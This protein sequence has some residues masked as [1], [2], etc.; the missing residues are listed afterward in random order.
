MRYR[1]YLTNQIDEM[2]RIDTLTGMYNRR[3]FALAYQ[4]LLET[5]QD[6][7]QLTIILADLDRL[8]Y[9]NDTF[10]H[11]EGD[12]AIRAVADA[13]VAVCPEGSLFN[14]FGGDEMLGVCRGRLEPEDIRTA[15]ADYF[16]KFNSNSD[17]PYEV[18]AS[19]GVY[20]TKEQDRLSFEELIERSDRLM[21]EEKERHRKKLQNQ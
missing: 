16:R 20:I 15:F 1:N 6:N 8:K 18:D 2:S 17:K 21:Y 14:R 9:I 7:L 13:L 4:K 19:I 3:G 12:F 5:E 10:G 11:K